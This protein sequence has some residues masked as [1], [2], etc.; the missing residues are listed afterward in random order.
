MFTFW[1]KG[2]RVCCVLFALQ[3]AFWAIYMGVLTP[4]IFMMPLPR[5]RCTGLRLFRLRCNDSKG[6]SWGRLGRRW[7]AI[8]S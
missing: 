5:A 1:L 8:S 4:S 3:S 2:L 7:L 6:L